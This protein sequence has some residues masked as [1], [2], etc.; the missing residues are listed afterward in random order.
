MK[1]NILKTMV[2]LVLGM[3]LGVGGYLLVDKFVIN[4][5]ANT[6]N[7]QPTNSNTNES[8][9]ITT[10]DKLNNTISQY[11]SYDV[12]KT[13]DNRLLNKYKLKW[14]VQKDETL[15]GVK[16]Y[17]VNN[18]GKRLEQTFKEMLLSENESEAIIK[19]LIDSIEREK[20][21]NSLF[22][23]FM[24]ESKIIYNELKD[25]SNNNYYLIVF[26][27]GVYAS[28]T[29]MV[30]DLNSKFKGFIRPSDGQVMYIQSDTP[31]FSSGKNYE[32]NTDNVIT[33]ES[34]NDTFNKVKYTIENGVMKKEIVESYSK[35]EVDCVMC[36]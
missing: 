14:E 31:V 7:N 11:L 32:I 5:D 22:N 8:K 17:L 25:T 3:A 1:N 9:E 34:S 19:D 2:V 33:L 36:K 30:Y 24:P 29:G 13:E 27:D 35:N 10:I 23:Y 28:N 21:L 4:K 20:S 12:N 15:N 6:S 16:L 18:N 26:D